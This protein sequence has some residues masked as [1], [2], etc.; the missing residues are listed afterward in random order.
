MKLKSKGI[1]SMDEEDN[2]FAEDEDSMIFDSP[3]VI[4]D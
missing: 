4:N 1:N 2:S 3:D